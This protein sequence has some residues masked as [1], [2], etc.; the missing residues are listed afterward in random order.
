MQSEK[1]V[2]Q[3]VPSSLPPSSDSSTRAKQPFHIPGSV[4]EIQNQDGAVLLDIE[5]GVCFSLTPVAS[6]IWQL[7]KVH[8]E[9]EQIADTIAAEFTAPRNLVERD[10]SEF[11]DSLHHHRLLLDGMDEQS[12]RSSGGWLRRKLSRLRARTRNK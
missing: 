10:I 2:S 5:Q 7:L 12:R 11:L 4:K 8:C 1:A 9:L 3:E 6:R